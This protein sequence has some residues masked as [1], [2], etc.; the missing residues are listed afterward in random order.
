[1][2][3][4]A[5]AVCGPLATGSQL[6]PGSQLAAQDE[7]ATRR[8]SDAR[9]KG[10]E[11]A[12]VTV[13]ELADF[14]CPFCRRFT[15]EVL[16]R[17]DSAYVATGKVRWIYVN[18][19]LPN[20]TYAWPAAEAAMCVGAAGGD[21]WRAHDSLFAR[22]DEWTRGS[23]T[24]EIFAAIAADAGADA[25]EWRRCVER[26]LVAPVLVQDLLSAAQTGASG[27]PAFVIDQRELFV[28]IRPFEEWVSVL[29]AALERA[30]SEGAA[31][32]DSAAGGGR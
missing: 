8:A 32:E 6:A 15:H 1:M 31:A 21:F 25:G 26:D 2:L 30:A 4:A 12:P 19:P 7:A 13:F 24:A 9:V 28:G 23:G 27:T 18:Y 14:Q 20:H 17:I 29:D 3:A 11:E 16:P 10:A 22:Q 5:A